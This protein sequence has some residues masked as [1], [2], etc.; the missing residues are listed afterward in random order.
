MSSPRED[1][2][3]LTPRQEDTDSEVQ[4]MNDRLVRLKSVQPARGRA[5]SSRGF[6]GEEPRISARRDR[7]RSGR[8]RKAIAVHRC[9]Q[10]GHADCPDGSHSR[11]S[12]GAQPAQPPSRQSQAPITQLKSKVRGSQTSSSRSSDKGD[13][14][15][16]G[17]EWMGEDEPGPAAPSR[18]AFELHRE[19]CVCVVN[20]TV[21]ATEA[22][23]TVVETK[24]L[25]ELAK[26]L[27]IGPGSVICVQRATQSMVTQLNALPPPTGCAQKFHVLFQGG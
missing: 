3:S 9:S 21:P 25:T 20:V 5:R 7:T 4:K 24:C 19:G 15:S 23:S 22:S 17:D 1:D 26:D 16:E 8:G 27:A 2:G 12:G 13:Y 6:D 10:M 11:G 14:Q 18:E